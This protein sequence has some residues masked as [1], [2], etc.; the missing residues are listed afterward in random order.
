MMT[1]GSGDFA[2]SGQPT[3][4]LV[5]KLFV[6]IPMPHFGRF[7]RHLAFPFSAALLLAAGLVFP[8]TAI[9]QD[10]VAALP[11]SN[12]EIVMGVGLVVGLN[13]TGDSEVDQNLVDGSIVGVLKRA[14]LDMWH[15]QIR[16]GRVAKVIVTAQ[17][18]ANASEG[19][20]LIA[21]VSAVG[22]A[23]SLAGGTLL[24]TPLRDQNGKLYAIGQGSIGTGGQLAASPVV[25]RRHLQQ[26][27]SE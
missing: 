12:T 10:T 24:A 14:G 3:V 2:P 11:G 23:T 13:G 9:A 21:S 17:L 16:P 4:E 1:I 19:T 25:D 26:L 18:Q 27:A 20:R 6:E 15:D 22:N 5:P 8:A 7:A